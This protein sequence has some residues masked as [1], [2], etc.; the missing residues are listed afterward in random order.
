MVMRLQLRPYAFALREPLQTAHGRWQQRSGW[1]LRLEQRSSA[2]LGWGEVAPLDPA[3]RRA[4]EELM[5]RWHEP[6]G[7]ECTRASLETLLLR[8]P[9]PVAFALGAA[10]G[11]LDGLVGR[12]DDGERQPWLPAPSSARLLPAGAAMPAAL[13]RLLA[14]AA[15]DRPP[16][17]KWKVAASDPE[18]EWLLLG[19]LLERLPSGARLRLDANGG[20]DRSNADR[21]VRA[22]E[23]EPRLDWLE[24]PL[25]TDDLQGHLELAERLP[26]ALDESLLA[27]PAW[28]QCWPGW[29]VRRPL[30]EGDPRSLLARL[31]AGE[32][33]LMLSTAF[34][35]GIGMRWLALLAALQMQG[36]TP[37]APGLATGWCP[38]GPLFSADPQEVWDAAA[39]AS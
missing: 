38:E 11:E 1:L 5:A 16:T 7:I 15:P 28:R 6:E 14:E 9:A 12:S 18:Q 24:Q 31:R 19:L 3:E 26:V 22:L 35:T 21:W 25:A 33:R 30:L 29:Q 17:V 20:W 10:L 23:G 4:C 13:D 37:T 8:A 39:G 32:P 36:P 27:H 2:R 34:E